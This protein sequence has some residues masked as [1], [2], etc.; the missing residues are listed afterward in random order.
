M[1]YRKERKGHEGHKENTGNRKYGMGYRKERKG[2]KGHKGERKSSP[3]P[4]LRV[5][6]SK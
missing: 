1:D 6:K 5:R 2:H 4:L 3:M